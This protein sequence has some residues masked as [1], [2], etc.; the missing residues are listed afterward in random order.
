[1]RRLDTSKQRLLNSIKKND[2]TAGGRDVTPRQLGG[3]GDERTGWHGAVTS[4]AG[5]RQGEAPYQRVQV[6]R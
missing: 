5:R 3:R 1:M 4:P 6:I 2:P